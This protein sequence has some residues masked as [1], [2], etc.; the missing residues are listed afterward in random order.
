M[1]D[2][3]FRMIIYTMK[4]GELLY[5]IYKL[6]IF[7]I[8]SCFLNL[9]LRM[10]LMPALYSSPCTFYYRLI[11]CCL[12]FLKYLSTKIFTYLCWFLS[13]SLPVLILITFGFLWHYL[14]KAFLF[15]FLPFFLFFIYGGSIFI[16]SSL[17]QS[18]MPLT[19]ADTQLIILANT[20]LPGHIAIFWITPHFPLA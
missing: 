18:F 8:S 17:S 7:I 20:S 9:H 14:S 16:P 1:L 13:H 6:Y 2:I 15:V 3:I 10:T 11:D 5:N 19:S 4:H 12:Q